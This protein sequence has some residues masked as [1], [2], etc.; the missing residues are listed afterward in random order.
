MVR[1]SGLGRG[2]GALIPTEVL[3][4]RGAL[5]DLAITAVRPNPRQPR[6]H[7]DEEALAALT[8]SVREIGILQPILVRRVSDD[9]Y[10]LI[11]GE[12]RW[13][14]AR[15]ANSRRAQKMMWRRSY[16][17]RFWLN[18]ASGTSGGGTRLPP[19]V[20]DRCQPHHFYPNAPALAQ[21]DPMN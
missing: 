12:R 2:L 6:A 16:R 8:A 14:A 3:K 19:Q 18:P 1:R 9:Q 4:D 7:F 11:A 15:R 17:L 13:R 21:P 20:F 10:E 5:A